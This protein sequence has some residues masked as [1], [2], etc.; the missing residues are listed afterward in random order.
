MVFMLHCRH[1]DR[2]SAYKNAEKY[3]TADFS[4]L[5]IVTKHIDFITLLFQ[6]PF[7]FLPYL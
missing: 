6:S 5:A 7:V 2:K 3:S 4:S 1:F